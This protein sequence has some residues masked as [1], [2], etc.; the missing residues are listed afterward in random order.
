LHKLATQRT[1]Q[2][3]E[4]NLVIIRRAVERWVQFVQ[5]SLHTS[6]KLE[7]GSS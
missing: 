7:I 4:G 2:G 1:S 3:L 6:I 5:A